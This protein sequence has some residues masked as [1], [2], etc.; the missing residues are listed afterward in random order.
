MVYSASSSRS[1][2]IK[3]GSLLTVFALLWTSVAVS[4]QVLTF[5]D[6]TPANEAV[7]VEL[8][9][10]FQI[11]FDQPLPDVQTLQ[12][13][14]QAQDPSYTIQV[15]QSNQVQV[16]TSEAP[17]PQ[18]AF[19]LQGQQLLL[20]PVE[21]LLPSTTYTVSV[22]SQD[23]LPLAQNLQLTFKTKPEYTYDRDVQPLLD[24][25]CVGCHRAG[26][27]QQSSPLDSYDAVL[28]YVQP[29]DAGSVLLD[30]KWTTR[31]ASN[32]PNTTSAITPVGGGIGFRGGRNPALAYLRRPADENKGPEEL[33]TLEQLGQWT[34]DQVQLIATWIIRD[35]AAES[36]EE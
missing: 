29:G 8:A 7:D 35:D 11:T 22:P 28:A 18:L 14:G 16:Q 6:S 24:A 36:V 21:P 1:F 9:Q 34:P 33:Y 30:S 10:V 2:W 5:V 27:S 26:A 13:T 32:F 19:D 23:N 20:Q 15:D 25:G 4:Q 12:V 31:H 17:A 3:L